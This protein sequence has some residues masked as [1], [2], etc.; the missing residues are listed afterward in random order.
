MALTL[1]AVPPHPLRTLREDAGVLLGPNWYAAAMGTGILAV[2]WAPL[3]PD[4]AQV[5]WVLAA[6]VLV[7]VSAATLVHRRDY[8]GHAVQVH[9]YGAP[10]M[11]LMAVGAATL[12]VHPASWAVALDAVLWTAGTVLGVATALGVPRLV[13]DHP[14]ESVG[15]WWLMPVVP[16]TVSATTGALL[17]PHLPAG[18]VRTAYLALCYALLVLSLVGTARVLALLVRRVRAHGWGPA[19]SVPTW[20]IVLGPLGQSVTAVH[21]LGVVS[22]AVPDLLVPLYGVPVLTASLV[23][24]VVAAVL[25]VRA[26]P[27]FSLTWWSFTFPVGT[28]TTAA[29]ALA[30]TAVGLTLVGLLTV[31]WLAA[32]TGTARGIWDGSLLRA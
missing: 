25:V 29:V 4:V 9:F 21:H 10:A 16:P 17:A 8:R 14:L 6:L 23:W 12:T 26:R 31:G 3:V 2:V 11:G 19:A 27:G 20:F 18:G 30:P 7:A 13:R 28:V 32:A 24:L 22:P 5:V 1:P 15:P